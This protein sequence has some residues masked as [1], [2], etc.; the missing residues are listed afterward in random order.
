MRKPSPTTLAAAVA[1]ALF[2]HAADA[3]T[4]GATNAGRTTAGPNAAAATAGT[5]S[6]GSTNASPGVTVGNNSQ[7][8]GTINGGQ[9]G[10]TVT[11]GSTNQ[12]N[13]VTVGTPI[14]GANGATQGQASAT[15]N[16]TTPGVTP[17]ATQNL[18]NLQNLQQLQG[19]QL[20]DSQGRILTDANGQPLTFDSR[21]T[22][23]V[24]PMGGV[25]TDAGV[26]NGT[27]SNGNTQVVILNPAD[28]AG[29]VTSTPELDRA[30]RKELNKAKV[31]SRSRNKQL[32]NTIAPRTNADR[33][34]Q[35][36]DDP[37]SP[38]LAT[39]DRSLPRY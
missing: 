21:G 19:A 26:T 24:A 8:S 15:G 35:M 25:A 31:A 5:S 38:A 18:Q 1:I 32:L 39:P 33:T 30:T 11:L 2:A 22:V 14:A 17:P 27:G 20:V 9:P 34:D 3:Q 36:A 29:S 6:S 12:G 37:P 23:G 16:G 28:L 4:R 13:V 10:N 7:G